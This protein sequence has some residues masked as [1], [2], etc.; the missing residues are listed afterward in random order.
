MIQDK[1]LKQWATENKVVVETHKSGAKV[2]VAT[3]KN[4]DM[5]SLCDYVVSSHT[6]GVYW[7]VKRSYES[8]VAFYESLDMT[9]SD[10]QGV[11]DAQDLMDK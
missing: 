10:A 5:F 7:L 2:V 9:T 6:G 4:P 3:D 1:T 8:R 11:V